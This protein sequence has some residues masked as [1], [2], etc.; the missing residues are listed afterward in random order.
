MKNKKCKAGKGKDM[1]Y[2]TYDTFNIEVKGREDL[3]K[4]ERISLLRTLRT[5]NRSALCSMEPL[6]PI[7]ISKKVKIKIT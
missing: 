4:E 7:G 5:L 2:I 3:T 6:V 1:K